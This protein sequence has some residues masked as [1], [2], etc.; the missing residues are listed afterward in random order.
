MY[1]YLQLCNYVLY[2]MYTH[3]LLSE[4]F[5]DILFYS[6]FSIHSIL[7]VAFSPPPPPPR[8]SLLF[9]ITHHSHQPSYIRPFFSSSSLVIPFPPPSFLR[10]VPLF[11][12]HALTTLT[13]FP[14]LS[15]RFPP[16]SLY[17]SFFHLSC[18]SFLDFL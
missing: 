4:M 13:S 17:S 11:A 16:L 18:Q 6:P 5:D 1:V 12:S 8:Q 3:G 14:G 15:L 2:F 9:Y 10:S 7:H